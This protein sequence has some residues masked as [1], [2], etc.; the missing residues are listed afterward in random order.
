MRWT[1]GIQLVAMAAATIA[2]ASACKDPNADAMGS[3]ATCFTTIDSASSPVKGAL[4]FYGHFY[5]DESLLL[6]QTQNG[7][8]VTIAQGTPATERTTFTLTGL[9]SGTNSFLRVV[10]CK[11]GQDKH[12]GLKDY[13]VL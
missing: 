12:Y 4:T 2:I 13:F 6:Q 9:P 5:P 8:S 3:T 7:S 10:S 1:S 11:N